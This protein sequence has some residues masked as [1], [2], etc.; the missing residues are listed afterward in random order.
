VAPQAPTSPA[1]IRIR[2]GGDAALLASLNP[3]QRE[4][5]STIDGPLLVLAGA[6]TGKTRVITTRIAYLVSLGVDPASILAVT[7][8]NKAAGE[9]RER[10]AALIGPKAKD[11]TVGTFHAFCVRVLK[12]HGPAI[13]LPRKF[14]ICD[15]S[16]Q[17]SAVKSAMRELRVHETAMHPSAVMARMSLAKNR[18][19]TAEGFLAE[20]SGG[21]DQLV[22]SVWQRYREFLSRTRSLDFDDLLLETVRLLRDHDAVREAYR[23]R[24]RF[25][26]VD[27]YQDTNHAQYEIVT[28]IGGGHRNVCVVGDDDQSIYGWRGAD[29]RKILGFHRDFEGAKVVRLQTNYR[30][31]APILDAANKVI[32]RNAS[33]H[34]KAL[35]SARG[36]GEHVRFARLKDEV[37]EAQFVVESIRK[38]S[39]EEGAKPGDF[40]ILCRTQVQFRPFEGEL[41]ANGLPYVVVGGM[42]F[43]DRKEVRDI[44]AYLR[45]V[46][47]PADETSLLRVINTPSRGVG[48][49]SLDRVLAFAT[50][51]GIA[52]GAAFERAAEIDGLAPQA[53]E[54][55]RK[56][57]AAIDGSGLDEAGRDLVPRLEAFLDTISY[58]DE[59]TRL[60]PD[61]MTREARWAGVLEVLNFAENHVR[62]SKA[63]S[64]DAF[65][66]ELA[67][68]GDDGPG[69]KK[70]DR[71]KDA[72]TLMTLHAAKG[73]EFPHVFLPGM[74]EGLLP[75]ARSAAEGSVEEER[76]LAYVGITR[77]MKTLAMTFAFE[78]AKYGR[79]ARSVPS[80]FLYEAQGD[81]VPAGWVGIEATAPREDD[82]DPPLI[83]KG[84]RGGGGG[85][86]A[87]RPRIAARKGAR[88]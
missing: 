75:H 19:E 1:F 22:G 88:R 17:L 52:A 5:V 74:E 12:E 62:R 84:K 87:A 15:A 6:G 71:R 72:V 44:V 35:E 53:V 11:I 54:G 80:R 23:K 68:S 43:F 50:E 9:M 37:S 58:R 77:A 13:G 26:L 33:R 7:F 16:D 31:T 60:Y 73:L 57:R 25:V 29:I 51:E 78:R 28:Q 46:V 27:E 45:L 8:T 67:L 18:M 48:K 20:G 86:K 69:D 76:R 63:P 56:L 34:D 47:N 39:A 70:D 10:V 85:G 79:L 66:D 4:A 40:A 3:S 61:P 21:R 32:R 38:R 14:T 59:V 36:A 83:G 82:G 65:L 49:A 30:S 42:S 2:P 55:Y 64:L 41:R 24:Y 81:E